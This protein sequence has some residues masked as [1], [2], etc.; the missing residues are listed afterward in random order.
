MRCQKKKWKEILSLL[1]NARHD[2]NANEHYLTV[3]I[4]L[5]SSRRGLHSLLYRL[6][7]LQSPVTPSPQSQ[8]PKGR[9][10]NLEV[11]VHKHVKLHL[12]PPWF[13][14]LAAKRSTS[15][16]SRSS[17]KVWSPS[18]PST[19]AAPNWRRYVV[20]ARPKTTS[21]PKVR[22][23]WRAE[24]GG[25]KTELTHM[26]NIKDIIYL[27]LVPRFGSR[28]SHTARLE[29]TSTVRVIPAHRF[30]L[31][32]DSSHSLPTGLCRASEDGEG[33]PGICSI[34]SK[35]ILVVVNNDNWK[36]KLQLM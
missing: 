20:C 2:I 10:K 14:I 29:P 25:R 13:A 26:K 4:K 5:W 18:L 17:C 7:Y 22:E 27:G 8:A 21:S 31:L 32:R 23:E 19:I 33:A 11:S 34:S 30:S 28:A 3:G 16:S 36:N 35:R 6:L 12:I 1:A 9:A 15:H 24:G